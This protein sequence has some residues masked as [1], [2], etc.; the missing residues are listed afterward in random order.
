[1]KRCWGGEVQSIS[2]LVAIGVNQEGYREILGVAEGSREDSESWRNF[3]RYQK[4]R[5]LKKINLLFPDKSLGLVETF[6]EFYPDAKWQR[7]VVHFFI[8]VC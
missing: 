4:S 2:V 1:M 3:F 5:G 6:W 7:C 8:E